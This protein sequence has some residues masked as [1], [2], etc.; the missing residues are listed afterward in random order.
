MIFP[1]LKNPFKFSIL[2][3]SFETG[4]FGGLIML[5][6]HLT[7]IGLKNLL[8]LSLYFK[9]VMVSAL[10]KVAFILCDKHTLLL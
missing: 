1:F 10:F 9:S 5:F 7:F 2:C 3:L 8:F 4:V 6:R